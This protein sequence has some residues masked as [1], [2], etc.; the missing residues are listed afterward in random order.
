[1]GILSQSNLKG[2]PGATCYQQ[3]IPTK[4]L[5]A[6]DLSGKRE[7][8]I[9]ERTVIYVPATATDEECEQRKQAYIARMEAYK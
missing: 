7:V 3:D 4:K 5:K 6:G 1:M 8:R 9:D 2:L